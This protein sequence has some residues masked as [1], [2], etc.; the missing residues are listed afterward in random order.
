M[1]VTLVVPEVVV[2]VDADAAIDRGA[3]R[4]PL[5]LVRLR[6]DITV[7]DVPSFGEGAQPSNG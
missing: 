7:G 3:W 5:R 2:E 6:L 1:D 4:H